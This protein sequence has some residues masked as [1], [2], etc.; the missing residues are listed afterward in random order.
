MQEVIYK[1]RSIY[2]FS[3]QFLLISSFLIILSSCDIVGSISDIFRGRDIIVDDF[4]TDTLTH[5]GYDFSNGNI[6]SDY[7]LADGETINWCPDYQNPNPNY[8]NHD[9]WIWWRTNDFNTEFQKDY[10]NIDLKTINSAPSTW[11]SVINPLLT[12]HCYVV[13]CND[14]YAKFKVLSVGFH[15]FDVEVKYEYSTS[16]TFK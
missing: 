3:S 8:I 13:K 6:P 12:D 2:Q 7:T 10:G 4:V 5:G 9:Q 11:D 16:N 14:G 15:D 1:N